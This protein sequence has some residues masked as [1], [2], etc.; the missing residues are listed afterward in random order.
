MLITVYLI[1]SLSFVAR[2]P[3]LSGQKCE[4]DINLHLPILLAFVGL[5]ICFLPPQPPTTTPY[6]SSSAFFLPL[7]LF[8]LLLFPLFLLTVC[9]LFPVFI[10]LFMPV[11]LSSFRSLEG[12][13]SSL[14]C[15]ACLSVCP[16]SRVPAVPML[17]ADTLSSRPEKPSVVFG[18]GLFPASC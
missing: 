18:S 4:Q 16:I 1:T 8:L 6:S 2:P 13:L 17:V 14:F 7:R 3:T 5:S 11:C 9:L 10:V 12:Q 15:Y